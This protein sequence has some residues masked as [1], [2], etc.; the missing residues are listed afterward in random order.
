MKK[1]RYKI[2]DGKD[3]FLSNHNHF[4]LSNHVFK[5]FFDKLMFVVATD[6]G[7]PP[8]AHVAQL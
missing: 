1:N 3:K 7:T 4:S 5:S 2:K 6:G 8:F